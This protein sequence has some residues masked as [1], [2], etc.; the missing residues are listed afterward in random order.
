MIFG[1]G[2]LLRSPILFQCLVQKSPRD[3]GTPRCDSVTR[4]DRC[5]KTRG[6]LSVSSSWPRGAEIRAA[7]HTPSPLRALWTYTDVPW[8]SLLPTFVF[9]SLCCSM[10]C[11]FL[12]F[13]KDR[14]F[15]M[16]SVPLN[17]PSFAG[18]L[19]AL[20]SHPLPSATSAPPSLCLQLCC[21][22]LVQLHP[23]CH[24][25]LLQGGEAT[26]P[27]EAPSGSLIHL[28]L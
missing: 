8:G 4:E 1:F 5:C 25:L 19:L 17:A 24:L 18:V 3:L 20:I 15:G 14:A 13:L 10:W 9:V 16:V 6:G 27:E 12:K 26:G 2:L 28:W 23:C 22:H 21:L 7:S 11:E